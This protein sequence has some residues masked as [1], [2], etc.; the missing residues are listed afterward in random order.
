MMCE[1]KCKVPIKWLFSSW[2]SS[3]GTCPLKPSERSRHLRA[4]SRQ[5]QVRHW[6]NIHQYA[7]RSLQAGAGSWGLFFLRSQSQWK[8][9]ERIGSA[10]V[11]GFSSYCSVDSVRWP[12]CVTPA[13]KERNIMWRPPHQHVTG[14]LFACFSVKHSLRFFES[15]GLKTGNKIIESNPAV[16]WTFHPF[17]CSYLKL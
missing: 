8:C 13:R 4:P 1:A 6:K 7:A 9:H 11:L 3:D 10:V 14:F 15:K 17:F 16:T 2:H 12:P 5:E